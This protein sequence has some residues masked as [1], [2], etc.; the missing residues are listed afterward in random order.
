MTT[1]PPARVR[2]PFR[3]D[4]ATITQ[5]DR[6]HRVPTPPASRGNIVAVTAE[7][8]AWLALRADRKVVTVTVLD[9]YPTIGSATLEL[10]GGSPDTVTAAIAGETLAGLAVHVRQ[11]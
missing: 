8:L 9:P 7:D 4:Q 6:V 10:D 11:A 5:W 2:R 3:R 1:E